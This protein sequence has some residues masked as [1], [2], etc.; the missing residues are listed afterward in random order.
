MPCPVYESGARGEG[1]YNG[2]AA[3][4]DGIRQHLHFM[5]SIILIFPVGALV[6]GVADI[7]AFDKIHPQEAYSS[8]RES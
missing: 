3:V 5:G 1:E 2:A 6:A 7:I 4:F 8:S